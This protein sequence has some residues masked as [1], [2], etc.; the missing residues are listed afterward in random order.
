MKL[1]SIR[2]TPNPTTHPD[3]RRPQNTTMIIRH[4]FQISRLHCCLCLRLLRVREQ[5]R[6]VIMTRN[7]VHSITTRLFIIFFFFFFR[8]R[9]LCLLSSYPTSSFS[10]SS[11]YHSSSEEEEDDDEVSSSDSFKGWSSWE[12]SEIL[13]GGIKGWVISSKRDLGLE[14]LRRLR[15]LGLVVVLVRSSW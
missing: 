11:P 4:H 10:S 3:T 5:I 7:R 8:R 12:Y 14:K 2:K 15:I 13:L 1:R 9:I 6:H